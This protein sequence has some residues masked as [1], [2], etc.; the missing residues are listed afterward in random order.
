MQTYKEVFVFYEETEL[1]TSI[2]EVEEAEAKLNEQIK[3]M[4]KLLNST[5]IE[6]LDSL[7]GNVVR[8]YEMQ[9]FAFAQAVY[10]I[11]DGWVK[12]APKTAEQIKSEKTPRA[13]QATAAKRT[14]SVGKNNV[15]CRTIE[16]NGITKT[17]TEWIEYLSV[18]PGTFYF[19]LNQGNLNEWISKKLQEEKKHAE[20]N[21]G[22]TINGITGT[23]YPCRYIESN[24]MRMNCTEWIAFLKCSQKTFYEKLKKGE[25]VLDRWITQRLLR[26]AVTG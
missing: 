17:V 1:H 21:E 6:E 3:K 16:S 12:V 20:V 26:T 19:H 9:G 5:T 10:D 23:G 13:E 15:P 22:K 11:K 14:N 25:D 24:G 7:I 8:S 18:S 4:A 2:A